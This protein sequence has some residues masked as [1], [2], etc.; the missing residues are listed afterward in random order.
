MKKMVLFTMALTA[1]SLWADASCPLANLTLNGAYVITS[2]GTAGG[3]VFNNP[4]SPLPFAAVGKILFDGQGN[5]QMWFTVNLN[6]QFISRA[7]YAAPGVSGTYTVNA[8]CSGT[9]TWVT[10]SATVV[11]IDFVVTPNGKQL[12]LIETDT[13]TLITGTAV[14]ITP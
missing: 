1:G 3:P 12:T 14:R 11:H 6:G 2:T 5:L 8:D 13:G 7:N 4:P 9:A 10:P